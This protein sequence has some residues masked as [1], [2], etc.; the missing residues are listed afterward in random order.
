MPLYEYECECGK[1]FEAIRDIKD[2]NTTTCKCG[3]MISP[4][5]SAWG[6]VIFAGSFTV[7]GHDGTVLDKRQTT[8]YIPPPAYRLDNP[9]L[10]EV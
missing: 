5:I 4:K 2:R 10:V 9:N 8:E 1:R 7:I 3:R 6:R